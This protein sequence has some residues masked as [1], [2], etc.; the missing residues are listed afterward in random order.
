M[1]PWPFKR[2]AMYSLSTA[3]RFF[4]LSLSLYLFY[5]VYSVLRSLQLR[6]LSGWRERERKTFIL[7][8]GQRERELKERW[9]KSN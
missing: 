8:K 4:V 9:K 3:S 7:N 1:P 6:A 5:L 2:G